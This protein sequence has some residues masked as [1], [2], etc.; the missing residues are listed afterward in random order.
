M[1][2]C[3]S[4]SFTSFHL[5]PKVELRGNFVQTGEAASG[6][7]PQAIRLVHLDAA[8]GAWKHHVFA[9]GLDHDTSGTKLV[10]LDFKLD[11]TQLVDGQI[12]ERRRINKKEATGRAY[13][14]SE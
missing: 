4:A 3:F 1:R 8:A 13:H 2:V 7:L 10:K 6:I 14:E 12:L 11:A 9:F 5:L